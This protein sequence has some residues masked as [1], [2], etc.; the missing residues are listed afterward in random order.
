MTKL[1]TD[2]SVCGYAVETWLPIP[3]FIGYE[4]SDMG[5]V[6]SFRPKNGKGN[7]QEVPRLLKNLSTVKKEYLRVGLLDSNQR[8]R[9]FPI[10]TLVLLAFIGERPSKKHQACHFDG[11]AKN[12]KLSNLSWGTAQQNAD[13]RKR[14]GTQICG[15]NVAISVL[16][17][18]Q[19]KEIKAALPV[20]K[21]GFGKYFSNKF[22]VG[23]SAISAIKHNQT[24]K[25]VC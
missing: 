4:V 8:L 25:H 17:V 3:D 11:N 12:N 24:W 15:E 5:N 19:V 7:L 2:I 9:H 1:L 6:R 21:K 14:H 13:D 16:T 18:E 22:G 10:H 20:W 23:H